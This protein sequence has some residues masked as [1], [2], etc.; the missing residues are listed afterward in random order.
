MTTETF[1]FTNTDLCFY[2]S[3]LLACFNDVEESWQIKAK[4]KT[5]Q[6][7]A[8]N[9][10]LNPYRVSQG[11]AAVHGAETLFSLREGS[12]SCVFAEAT[13]ERR[14][15]AV[16]PSLPPLAF[17]RHCCTCQRGVTESPDNAATSANGSRGLAAACV[18][19]VQREEGIKRIGE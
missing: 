2:L 9:S 6:R 16:S 4:K 5:T 12:F 1:L 14:H 10:I 3:T 15:P 17:P 11:A 19:K 8:L 13:S 7:D 18:C